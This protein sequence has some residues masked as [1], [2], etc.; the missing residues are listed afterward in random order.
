MEK[1][2]HKGNNVRNFQPFTSEKNFHFTPKPVNVDNS[3]E[4]EYQ[5]ERNTS[6]Q[7]Q[8]KPLDKKNQK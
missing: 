4:E 7:L 5:L 1:F 6:K 3:F 2:S 8:F